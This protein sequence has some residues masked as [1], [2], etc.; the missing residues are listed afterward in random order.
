MTENMQ[1]FLEAA[2]KD[3]AL[4]EALN[5]ADAPE[6][7][8][9]KAKELGFELTEED[10]RAATPTGELSD[11]ELEDVAGGIFLNLTGTQWTGLGR[12]L[13]R[14]FGGN[15][16]KPKPELHN[17]VGHGGIGSATAKSSDLVYRIDSN[18]KQKLVQL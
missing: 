11:E 15:E 7:V 2:G 5:S 18:T 8:L 3:E 16:E 6:D 12:L 9:A 10:L 13:F 4:T 14:F 17:L 1:K